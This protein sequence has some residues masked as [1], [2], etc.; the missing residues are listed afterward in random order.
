[1][2]RVVEQKREFAAIE[3]GSPNAGDEIW[4][5]P[6]MDDHH[7]GVGHPCLVTERSIVGH[8]NEL[9]EILAETFDG[10]GALLGQQVRT[11]PPVGW[12]E[13]D[14]LMPARDELAHDAALEMRIAMV[15]VGHH[16]VGVEHELHD[17]CP[18]T[19]IAA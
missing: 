8:R 1:M 5:R 12:L 16:R 2:V 13:R 4:I 15:P 6:L 7:I 10:E 19:A 3:L 17:Q 14:H 11:A 9:G 18:A